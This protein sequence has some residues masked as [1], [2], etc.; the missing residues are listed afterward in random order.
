MGRPKTRRESKACVARSVHIHVQKSDVLITDLLFAD[1][2][3][4]NQDR[5]SFVQIQ[6]RESVH[7]I[8]HCLIGLMRER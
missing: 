4:S 3:R 7:R 1:P 6:S 8:C 2:D 5:R